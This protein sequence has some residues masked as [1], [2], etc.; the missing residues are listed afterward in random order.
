MVQLKPVSRD[1]LIAEEDGRSEYRPI[2]ALSIVGVLLAAASI[3]AI[4]NVVFWVVPLFAL[5]VNV[6]ALRQIAQ[7]SPPPLGR[8]AALAGV[9]LSLIFA[10]SAPLATWS[11]QRANQ[12]QAIEAA[13]AWFAALRQNEPDVAHQWTLPRWRRAG[14]GEPVSIEYTT[15]ASQKTLAT[16][17]EGPVVRTLLKLGKRAHV[18]Y[19]GNQSAA[20]GDEERTLVDLYS[21]TVD[22][23]RR[24]TTFYVALT[25]K[26]RLDRLRHSWS[27]EVSSSEFLTCAPQAE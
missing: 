24:P 1:A 23:T 18:R 16:F 3:L 20:L 4:G 21:V 14:V 9:A 6:K 17:V 15:T 13:K 8:G 11:E 5:A 10:F 25:I 26:A 2:H 27:W 19:Q 22:E 7:E 12:W